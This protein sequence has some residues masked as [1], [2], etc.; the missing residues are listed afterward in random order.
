MHLSA[1]RSTSTYS[2][3]TLRVLSNS[4]S[5]EIATL[6]LHWALHGYLETN[7]KKRGVWS[8]DKSLNL[9][10]IAKNDWWLD[11]MNH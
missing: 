1:L 5:S 4:T 9:V 6:L 7:R 2:S 3:L 8:S 11:K 10:Q